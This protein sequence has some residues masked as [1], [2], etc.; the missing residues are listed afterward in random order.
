MI[1][2]PETTSL[3]IGVGRRGSMLTRSGQGICS[4][5]DKRRLDS[6]N[7]TQRKNSWEICYKDKESEW[8]NILHMRWCNYL[9]SFLDLHHIR[10]LV[11]W[12]VVPVVLQFVWSLFHGVSS[13]RVSALLLETYDL[14]HFCPSLVEWIWY[15]L[16]C[17]S[18]GAKSSPSL[19][20]GPGSSETVRV[21]DYCRFT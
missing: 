21:S 10:V 8:K 16:H 20:C 14:W 5:L 1:F 7:F 4:R 19:C 11:F 15:T 13:E 12:C 6:Q 3:T 17:Q 18:E 9:K 2:I